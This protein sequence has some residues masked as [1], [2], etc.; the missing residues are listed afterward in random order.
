MTGDRSAKSWQVVINGTLRLTVWVAENSSGQPEE[1]RL[2][3]L[4][5]HGKN[6][7]PMLGCIGEAISLGLRGGIPLA[8]FVGTFRGRADELGGPVVG[9]PH[10]KDCRSIIDYLSL[11]LE[12]RYIKKS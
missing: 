8:K 10:V 12:A 5:G 6:L 2:T 4:R 7:E 11:A 3:G 9:D 1:V